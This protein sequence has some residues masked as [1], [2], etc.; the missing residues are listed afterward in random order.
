MPHT[1]D[2][3]TT[4]AQ[5]SWTPRKIL[6]VVL[7]LALFSSGATIARAW[8]HRSPYGPEALHA[9]VSLESYSGD[10]VAQRAVDELAGAGR[11]RVPV[12]PLQRY[13]VGQLRFDLPREARRDD[14]YALFV[15]D[16][17]G[18]PVQEIWGVAGSVD[19]TSGWDGR[20]EAIAGQ[21]PWLAQLHAITTE[22]GFTDPGASLSWPALTS[23]PVTFV[24][25]ADP[26]VPD[27][28]MQVALVLLSGATVHWAHRVTQ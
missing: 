13:V 26:G 16:E 9:R 10:Q 7:L 11:L 3:A 6:I 25:L 14:D 24:A 21:Y 18:R 23:G 15:L 12:D 27:E 4:P 28:H 5:S 20:Y 8:S 1:R 2:V 19:V 17:A 22:D